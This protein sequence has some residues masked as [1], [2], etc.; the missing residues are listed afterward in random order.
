MAGYCSQGALCLLPHVTHHGTVPV[1]DNFC[2]YFWMNRCGYG[3]RCRYTHVSPEIV[4]KFRETVKTVKG[5]RKESCPVLKGEDIPTTSQKPTV[6]VD[7]EKIPP[8]LNKTGK[9]L[10]RCQV[11]D[12]VTFV[13]GS[14]SEQEIWPT[15]PML[16]VDPELCKFYKPHGYLP[17]E[18]TLCASVEEFLSQ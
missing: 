6:F 14:P 3:V 13:D 1:P 5:E 17:L 8:S 16:V 2:R 11:T 9:N 15:Y 4:K 18:L 12:S 10:K 7:S